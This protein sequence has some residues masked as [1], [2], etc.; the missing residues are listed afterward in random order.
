MSKFY[1]PTI[2]AILLCMILLVCNGQTVDN[3]LY[4]PFSP[5]FVKFKGKLEKL[6]PEDLIGKITE[7]EQKQIFNEVTRDGYSNSVLIGA[8]TCIEC[9]KDIVTQWAVSAHRFSSF[10]NPFYVASVTDL[11]KEPNGEIRSRWCASCHDP[12]LLLTGKFNSNVEVASPEAQAGLTCFLCHQIKGIAA[13]PVNGNYILDTNIISKQDPFLQPGGIS[14]VNDEFSKKL[15]KQNFM[16]PLYK[17]SEFCGSCHKASIP[18]EVNNFRFFPAQN[19]YDAWHNS[20]IAGNVAGNFS[21]SKT[22][23]KCQDCHMPTEGTKQGDLATKNGVIKSHRFLAANTALPSLRLDKD[24]IERVKSFMS[25][26]LNIDIFAI[27]YGTNFN[28][29]MPMFTGTLPTLVPGEEIQ[30]DVIVSNIGV[31]HTFPG[32]TLDINEAWVEFSLLGD[33]GELLAINGDLSEDQVLEKEAHSY[34]AFFLDSLSKKIERHNVA[35]IRTLVWRRTI[36]QGESDVVRYRLTIPKNLRKK[37][38]TLQARLL[39]RKFNKAFSLFSQEANPLGF[40]IGK[41]EIPVIEIASSQV[42]LPLSSKSKNKISNIYNHKLSR[43]DWIR[44]NSYGIAMFLQKDFN[45]AENTFKTTLSSKSLNNLDGWLNYCRTLFEQGKISKGLR[46][47][48]RISTQYDEKG[49]IFWFM[50]K[51]HFMR[52]EYRLASKLFNETIKLYPNDRQAWFMLGESLA[53]EGKYQESIDAFDE[54]F[55]IDPTNY[56]GHYIK[57]RDLEELQKNEDAEKDFQLYEKYREDH[58]NWNRAWKYRQENT[59]ENREAYPI[60]YHS[61][62]YVTLTKD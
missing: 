51:G 8:M 27:R 48:K 14:K 39:W 7:S 59:S 5:S 10:N 38:V 30:V 61:L 4:Q 11:R 23:R 15:H 2:I 26:K 60:H 46:L 22:T 6:T 56:I 9:H 47:L 28:H 16:T 41:T 50:G 24:S 52:R 43:K 57:G 36:G 21:I 13:R 20:G 25:N 44:L 12:A 53:R 18:E 32:G 35:D 45:S 62:K 19:D 40:K 33:N 55:K 58:F 3:D 42:T 54:L 1:R 49:R 29:I 37:T 34:S 31:G 17:T